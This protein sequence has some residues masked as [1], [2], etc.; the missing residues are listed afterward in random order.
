MDQNLIDLSY[1][2]DVWKQLIVKIRT[3]DK[4]GLI[5]C[6]PFRIKRELGSISIDKN[7]LVVAYK[8]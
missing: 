6:C 1:L 5:Q 2:D 3:V 8:V 4:I 7:I